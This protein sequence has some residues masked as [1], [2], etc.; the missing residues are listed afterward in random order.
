[1]CHINRKLIL[2][3]V[4]LI[5]FMSGKPQTGIDSLKSV[6]KNNLLDDS[7][8]LA[9]VNALILN[10]YMYSNQDSTFCYAQML[11]EFAEKRDLKLEMAHSLNILGVAHMDKGD[12]LTSKKYFEQSLDIKKANSTDQNIA[13]TLNNLAILHAKFGNYD[14]SIDYQNQSLSISE[15]TNDSVGKAQSLSN[16][17]TLHNRM[18]SFDKALEYNILALQLSKELQHREGMAICYHNMGVV[19]SR[20]SSFDTAIYYYNKAQ[21][22][23]G[24]LNNKLAEAKTLANIGSVK[25]MQGFHAEAVNYQ[26]KSLEIYEAIGNKEGV[27]GT[28]INIGSIYQT[29]G[30]YASAVNYLNK[31]LEI[32]RLT[33]LKEN[34]AAATKGL[35]EAYK[36]IGNTRM[37]LSMYEQYTFVQDSLQSDK[38]KRELIHQEY[39]Y[40]YLQMHLADSLRNA[41]A[42][43]L[44]RKEHQKNAAIERTQRYSMIALFLLILTII[45]IVVRLRSIKIKNEKDILL[46][47]IEV[48][49][50]NT[51]IYARQNDQSDLDKQLNRDKICSNIDGILNDT[52]WNVL[53]VLCSKPT[54]NNREISEKISLSFEGVRSSLKKMYR[55]FD[56]QKSKENQRIALVIKAIQLSNI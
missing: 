3:I 12:F 23:Q 42:L 44:E 31:G 27:S 34:I 14:K 32:A 39:K 30:N 41:Q 55:I 4:L 9:A 15:K 13:N 24:E 53:T 29:Q 33:G 45:A 46:K 47:E 50:S 54:I 1:M 36:A 8:R 21:G 37:A 56:I 35:Y 20:K 52:D 18:G 16:I 43:E 5:V 6:W 40:K 10:H 28:Y 7:T 19:F 49:K 25:N 17:A 11:Y 26:N 51:V 48:L 38:N 22:L 2:L